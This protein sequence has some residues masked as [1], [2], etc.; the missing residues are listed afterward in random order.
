M[1]N[2]ATNNETVVAEVEPTLDE[3]AAE[4][5][6]GSTAEPEPEPENANS[7]EEPTEDVTEEPAEEDSTGDDEPATEEETEKTE[8]EESAEEEGVS[9]DEPSEGKEEK[10]KSRYQKR[11]EEL[12][13]KYREAER[14][15]DD[16]E[17][18]FELL[19][20][21][22]DELSKPTNKD[23]KETNP[24]ETP[25]FE[26]KID[27]NAVDKDG[28]PVY[29]LGKHDPEYTQDLIKEAL[30][31]DREARKSEAEKT[32][33]Q[34][35]TEAAQQQ[36]QQEWGSKVEASLEDMPDFVEKVQALDEPFEGIDPELGVYL[37]NTIM[38]LENGPAVLYHLAENLEE[39]KEIVNAGP[40]RAT[41]KLGQLSERLNKGK[42]E[43]APK[44][45]VSSAPKPPP[46]NKGSGVVK[47]AI[48]VDTDDLDE[49]EKIFLKK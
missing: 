45:K 29:P 22:L 11:V 28:N 14:R 6:G 26:S 37:G 2:D 21:K 5:F 25:V 47:G 24:E 35:E 1:Q 18:R 10:P 49:F 20:K 34:R 27:P 32:E 9:E 46:T 42:A 31:Q 43:P 40:G 19:E 33:K 17:R 12:N 7:D 4:L 36:L 38:G 39:A 3:F 41:I 15:A 23:E 8:A 30:Q 44:K 48:P 13:S 16:A